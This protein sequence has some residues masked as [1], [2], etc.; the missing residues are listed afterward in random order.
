MEI[1]EIEPVCAI[2]V[3]LQKQMDRKDKTQAEVSRILGIPASTLHDWTAGRI[4]RRLG[5]VKKLADFFKVSFEFMCFGSQT[6]QEETIDKLRKE[7]ME[8][9]ILEREARMQL[10]MFED[11]NERS[12]ESAAN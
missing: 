8:L 9:A 4:P 7:L 5:Q 12:Q 2:N 1:E 6:D 10:E 3:V 11:F